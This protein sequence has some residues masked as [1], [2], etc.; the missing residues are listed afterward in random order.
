[1]KPG[2]TAAGMTCDDAAL[3]LLLGAEPNQRRQA[4][5]HQRQC[6]LCHL[7][8]RDM[9]TVEEIGP[10]GNE[11]PVPAIPTPSMLITVVLAIVGVL[12]AVMTAPWLLAID[13]LGLLG[14]E[15]SAAHQVRDGAF[16]VIV[17]TSALLTVWRPRWAQPA[18]VIATIALIIQGVAGVLDDS[19]TATGGYETVHLLAIIA[20][21]LTGLT[22][23]RLAALGPV[24]GAPLGSVD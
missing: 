22:A 18:F 14:P 23:V 13:P 21:S 6:R 12:Q 1:M 4:E 7:G 11:P 8:E 24:R 3:A 17:A 16:G 15:V 9:V 20:A 5:R 2:S 19:L 10:T